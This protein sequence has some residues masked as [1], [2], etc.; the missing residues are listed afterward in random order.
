MKTGP[1][2]ELGGGPAELQACNREEDRRF[3]LSPVLFFLR[4]KL[5]YE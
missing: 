1:E 5:K 4:K 2:E 3:L